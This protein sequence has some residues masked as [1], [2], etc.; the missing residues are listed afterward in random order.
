MGGDLSALVGA[1]LLGVA[2]LGG[3]ALLVLIVHAIVDELK[4]GE[5]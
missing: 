3:L 2:G 4:R 1:V 5:E